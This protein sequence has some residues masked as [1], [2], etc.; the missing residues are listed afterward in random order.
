MI[1][2]YLPPFAIWAVLAHRSIG[3]YLYYGR[4]RVDRCGAIFHVFERLGRR[5]YHGLDSELRGILKEKGLREDDPFDEILLRSQV[6]DLEQ[7]C[8][9]EAAMTIAA[10]KLEGVI[11]LSSE[12]IV[13]QI[14]VGTRI[15]ATPVTHGMALPHFRSAAIEQSELVL[16]RAKNGVRMTLYN[17]QTLEESGEC[18][19]NALFFLVSPESNPTQHLRILARI[20]ERVDEDSFARQWNGAKHKNGLKEALLQ[21]E[22]FLSL[23]LRPD[24]IAGELIGLPLRDVV[25]A[26]GCLV[27]FLTR[28][29]ISFV[30]NGRSVLQECD[31]LTI[32]GDEIALA[33]IK[34]RYLNAADE[35]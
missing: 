9:F 29:G 4:E 31:R 5:R 26:E 1:I 25:L 27:A 23:Q 18:V 24:Q 32:I 14:M 30:P 35:E 7:E 15:G 6:V 21:S 3:W 17:P 10:H 22:R 12:E 34:D 8:S 33:E 13:E 11:P 19:V 2:C 16:V 28:G 20:A